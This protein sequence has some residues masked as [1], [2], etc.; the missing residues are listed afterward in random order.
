MKKKVLY[1]TKSKRTDALG[2]NKTYIKPEAAGGLLPVLSGG[3]ALLL[4]RCLGHRSLNWEQEGYTQGNCRAQKI[5]GCHLCSPSSDDTVFSGSSNLARLL[6]DMKR[7]WLSKSTRPGKL[8]ES[9]ALFFCVV[10]ITEC[11]NPPR[12]KAAQSCSCQVWSRLDTICL[13]PF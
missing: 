4:S 11:N 6:F 10:L 8:V 12:R 7:P 13:C 1:Q 2:M 3:R 9:A 5:I